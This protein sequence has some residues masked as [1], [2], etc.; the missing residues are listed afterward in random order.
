[1]GSTSFDLGD[2]TR[3]ARFA[4][5]KF[6]VE[7]FYSFWPGIEGMMDS[8]PHT[9]KHW[10]K[11]YIRSAVEADA[12]QVWGIGPPPKAVLI[13]FTQ[14]SIYPADRILVVPW[15]AGNF[16]ASMLPVLE[17]ALV[18]YA[19]L[20]ECATIEVRGRP[21]WDPHFKSIGMKREFVTWSYPVPRARIN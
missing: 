1:M 11:D 13:F 5:T 10:T 4:L 8:V 19:Q 6:T 7:E 18:N 2:G 17:A 3:R 16:T 21:G 12:L 15:G 20:N 9:W 14:V